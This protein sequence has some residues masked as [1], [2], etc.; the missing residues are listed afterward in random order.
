[1][2]R[3][4]YLRSCAITT[5]ILLSLMIFDPAFAQDANNQGA[6]KQSADEITEV[7]VTAHHK[8][9]TSKIDRDI[10][11]V[12]VGADA[13]SLTTADIVTKL[14]GVV[15]DSSN[16]VTIH[17]G[18]AVSFLIDGKPVRRDLALAI[19][20]SQI[21][22]VE[23]ITNPSAEYDSSSGAI[24]NIVLKKSA[25]LGWKGSSA[26][27]I[28]TLGGFDMGLNFTHGGAKW[29]FIGSVTMREIPFRITTD[30]ET[31]YDETQDG[32]YDAQ[33]INSREQSS[34][35]QLTL[36]S[37]L[38]RNFSND[39]SLSILFGL[40]V[41]QYPKHIDYDEDLTG[42]NYAADSTYTNLVQ[43]NGL[44]PYG[45]VSYEAKKVDN[46][47]LA[48]DFNFYSG[49]DSD[50]ENVIGSISRTI[51]VHTSFTFMQGGAD[52]DK[53]LS[54]GDILSTGFSLSRNKVDQLSDFTGYS[55]AGETERDDFNFNR[56]SYAVYTT[57]Q[58]KA[59]GI[60]IKAGMRFERL[61]QDLSNAEGDISGLKSVTH[62]LPTL[63][64]SK[65]LNKYN[66][67]R[68]SFTQRTVVPDAVDYNPFRKYDSPY[69]AKEG[70]P[71]LKP[72]SKN[73][74]E[75]SH[76]Y[77][78]DPFSFVQT[79]YYRDTKNDVNSYPSVGN[80]G[81]TV[82]S[83]ANLGTSKAYG[84]N[85][86]FKNTISKRIQITF[87]LDLF[88][89]E[90]TAPGA[91]N[92]YQSL[93]YDSLN[94]DLELDYSFNKK[95][96]ITA[97]VTYAGKNYTLGLMNP[98]AWTSNLKYTRTLDNKLSLTIELINGAVPQTLTSRFFAPGFSGFERVYQA[99]QLIRIGLAKS[100]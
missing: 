69:F 50:G 56:E 34:F 16:K 86:T 63:H 12:K 89:T 36:Q 10:Y 30:R 41:N 5:S 28:D 35:R 54:T 98:A 70:N 18:A 88:H 4:I 1:M 52:F 60:D 15:M 31:S 6:A 95:N 8:D 62:I 17:G 93:R 92:Q 45:S 33:A 22:R 23:V 25:A 87:D 91:L 78:K 43:F 90:I 46:Y 42:N 59:V 71:F 40:H 21:E 51:H 20:A 13:A 49:T 3:Q 72:S 67:I 76:A 77:E 11:D 55:G 96:Q 81:V 44:Y 66:T 38:I 79:L 7:T 39:A 27:K 65:A 24:I 99:S 84:Y 83:Y 29:N 47:H 97:N 64:L 58:T 53:N 68:A 73:Q 57:Y 19:P 82:L 32:L 48:S 9:V 85:F 94:S 75:L 80:D 14:P 2:K 74:A 100:F 61:D 37:K 26:G